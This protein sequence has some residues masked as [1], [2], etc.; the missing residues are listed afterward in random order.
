MAQWSVSSGERSVGVD[1]PNWLGALGSSLPMLGLS[2]GA[3]GRLVCSM[4]DDGGAEAYD[5]VTGVRLRVLPGLPKPSVPPP[6]PL[7]H[8]DI[9]S[10]DAG[11]FDGGFDVGFAD[12]DVPEAALAALGGAF[13]E[14]L[15][16][17]PNDWGR[18][19][20]SERME[21]VFERC[22]EIS[23]ASDVRGACESALRILNA[24]VPADAGAVLVAT[25]G[26]EF[27]RF[28]AAHGPSA[29]R[30]I[31]TA[32]PVDQGIAGFTHGFGMGVIVDD[33]RRD[34]R[35]YRRIDK[36]TGYSTR[37]VLS[38]PVRGSDGASLGCMELLNPP[39]GFQA[40][41]L[42]VA[43]GVASALGAWLQG[44]TV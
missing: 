22:A 7:H 5:P 41:D 30:V 16:A 24:L 20:V 35:H 4:G 14:E 15:S 3:L 26:G 2:Q 44:A 8:A 1:A 10:A 17:A 27:L 12:I 36:A 25:R 29:R 43:Q 23:A 42:E 9:A 13:G 34:E 21:L 37:A 39:S 38:V 33:A 32:I 19:S 31:D 11:R 28:A 40:D 18:P 6:P